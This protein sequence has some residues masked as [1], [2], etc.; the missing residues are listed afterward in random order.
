[1]SVDV[2]GPISSS[3]MSRESLAFSTAAGEEEDAC[4]VAFTRHSVVAIAVRSNVRAGTANHLTR[5]RNI[6]RRA[7]GLHQPFS[8]SAAR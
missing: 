6:L 8:T 4:E 3:V 1:M 7:V 2:H 5:M